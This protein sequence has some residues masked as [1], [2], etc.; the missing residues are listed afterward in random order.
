MAAGYL[1]VAPGQTVAAQV[2]DADALG[3]HIMSLACTRKLHAQASSDTGIRIAILMGRGNALCA[4]GAPPRI[5]RWPHPGSTMGSAMR[6][7]AA[8]VACARHERADRHG[9][10]PFGV[11]MAAVSRC[12]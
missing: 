12:R 3:G 9:I 2:D 4:V 10:V 7:V 6:D 5:G 11:S 1:G 8:L